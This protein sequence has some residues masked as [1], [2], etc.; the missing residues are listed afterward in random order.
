MPRALRAW[1]A[2]WALAWACLVGCGPRDLASERPYQPPIWGEPPGARIVVD[3][4]PLNLGGDVRQGDLGASRFQGFLVY[5][6]RFTRLSLGLRR[7]EGEGDPVVALYGPRQDG[8]IWGRAVAWDDDSGGLDRALLRDLQLPALGE[9]LVLVTTQ[10]R[11]AQGRF[12]LGITCAEGCD[13][14]AP[15]PPLECDAPRPCQ[16]GYQNDARGCRTCACLDECVASQECGAN[17]VC[18]Q[19]RCQDDCTCPDQ[20]AP[21]CG[22]DGQTYLN[23]CEARCLG[24]EV[25]SQGECPQS[26]PALDCALVCPTGLRLGDDGCPVCDCR[27]LCE[28][29]DDRLDPVCTRNGATAPNECLALCNGEQVAYA[30]QC[31]PTCAPL[32]CDLAC[33]AGFVRDLNGC[34]RCECELEVCEDDGRR[35]CGVNGVTYA[36]ACGAERAGVEV[37]FRGTC[38][39]LCE[40]PAGCPAPLSCRALGDGSSRLCAGGE[41]PCVGACVVPQPQTCDGAGGCLAGF[42]CIEGTCRLSCAC[43]PVYDPVCGQDGQTYL[44]ECVARCARQAVA[45][46]GACCDPRSLEACPLTCDNG[47]EV[48]LDGCEVCACRDA[49]PCECGEV[50]NEVCGEDGRTYLN[51]CE[52]RCAGQRAWREGACAP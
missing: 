27:D 1:P 35:V 13:H 6:G 38:P 30:G 12:E 40:G 45:K 20:V 39:R 34:E 31:L 18:V 43:S 9:Y 50:Q 33:P 17:Q 19:G 4:R 36:S 47:W 22:R 26:C 32:E 44:N 37:A 3:P 29:C 48:D 15:C 46:P 51:S 28:I 16:R 42:E 21:V 7:L 2:L 14:L 41:E 5:G 11:P 23:P 25:V 10:E 8:D 52:A 49:P 24:V